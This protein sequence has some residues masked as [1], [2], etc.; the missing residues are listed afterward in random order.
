[1]SWFLTPNAE[2]VDGP[3]Q[4]FAHQMH[5]DSVDTD[6]RGQR[7]IRI[8]Q[9]LCQLQ[10][11]ASFQ[12]FKRGGGFA[13]DLRNASRDDVAQIADLTPNMNRAILLLIAR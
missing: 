8:G 6:P 13:E 3:H 4:S 12:G 1:M 11:T 9:P 10:A 7:V 5:P 2:V